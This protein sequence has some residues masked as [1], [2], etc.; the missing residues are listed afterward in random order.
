MVV[1]RRGILLIRAS[2]RKKVDGR[3]IGPARDHPAQGLRR[4]RDALDGGSPPLRERGPA[5]RGPQLTPATTWTFDWSSAA[6][7]TLK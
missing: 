5:T 1:G 3:G 7:F 2:G 4:A 6:K